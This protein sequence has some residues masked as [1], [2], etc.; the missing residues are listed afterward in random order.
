VS[1]LVNSSLALPAAGER[2]AGVEQSLD[3]LSE[4]MSVY[5]VKECR[6]PY[7]FLELDKIKILRSDVGNLIRL[8]RTNRSV[9][10]IMFERILVLV[11]SGMKS[12]D[13]VDD[14]D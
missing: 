8:G 5:T 3:D 11:A 12:P 7:A 4:E 10:T 6:G 14:P 13:S 2:S 1:L 9:R